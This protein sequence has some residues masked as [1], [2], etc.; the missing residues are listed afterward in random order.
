MKYHEPKTS[1]NE[2]PLINRDKI[3]FSERMFKMYS[4][5][6]KVV[7]YRRVHADKELCHFEKNDN[8][9]STNMIN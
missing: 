8:I 3:S 4:C 1:N 2:I 5:Y 7:N 9:R 6:G